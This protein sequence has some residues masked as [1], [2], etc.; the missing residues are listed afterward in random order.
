M[1]ENKFIKIELVF[2]LLCWITIVLQFILMIQ[3]RVT[4]ILETTIRF[5]TF[6]TILS[7]ILVALVFTA[8]LLNPKG[9]FSFFLNPMNQS[10]IAVYIFVVGFV[11][12]LI[13]RFLWQPQGMQRIVDEM[14]HTII[15]IYYILFWYFRIN[16]K[17]ISWKN[18]FEWLI[19]P[20]VYLFVIMIRG[21]FSNYYPY[22]F[23]NVSTLGIQKVGLNIVLLTIFFGVVALVFIATANF[24]NNRLN[25]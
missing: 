4:A 13:L 2:S 24:K 11:Y 10:A 20:V 5:F 1:K 25:S 16:T 19:Y 8:I 6:F 15:P 9:K 22:P 12:N 14:L 3:N 18:V 7:N 23:V 17:S 21:N